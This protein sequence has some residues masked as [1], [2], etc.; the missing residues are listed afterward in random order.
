[1]SNSD[2]PTPIL[3]NA[4]SVRVRIQ[5]AESSC[6]VVWAGEGVIDIRK[7]ANSL[8]IRKPDSY[9]ESHEYANCL[10]PLSSKFENQTVMSTLMTMPVASKIRNEIL[11]PTLKNIPI[12]SK[13]EN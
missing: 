8:K 9:V 4:T 1:L 5:N 7:H 2:L 3:P 12:I 10:K 13:L 11:A 6:E